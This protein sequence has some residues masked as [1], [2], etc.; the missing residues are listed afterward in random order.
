MVL[1]RPTS[2]DEV[3]PAH[4]LRSAEQPPRKPREPAARQLHRD[5]VEHSRLPCTAAG[6]ACRARRFE[7]A[8]YSASVIGVPAGPRR[9]HANAQPTIEMPWPPA[10][11]PMKRLPLRIS[12]ATMSP[13]SSNSCT[14]LPASCQLATT[15]AAAAA[16]S[17]ASRHDSACVPVLAVWVRLSLHCVGARHDG[18]AAQQLLDRQPGRKVA[19]R[20]LWHRARRAERCERAHRHWRP[21]LAARSVSAGT[22][23]SGAGCAGDACCTVLPGITAEVDAGDRR[24]LD[25]RDVLG[26]GDA[27][28]WSCRSRRSR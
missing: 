27:A 5:A 19:A 10:R 11:V 21:V 7:R 17:P 23:P 4:R 13:V 6:S 24:V 9:R 1:P 20:R 18:P 26:R 8:A 28:A 14:W 2:P 22:L 15:A 3:S 25:R 12:A 16:R